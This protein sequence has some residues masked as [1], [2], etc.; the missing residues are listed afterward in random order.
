[1]TEV[2]NMRKM[3]KRLGAVLMAAV[4]LLSLVLP[5]Y[6]VDTEG[7]VV[8]DVVFEQQ[9]T[10]IGRGLEVSFTFTAID[11][12]G[13]A[14][15]AEGSWV[16]FHYVDT[17]EGYRRECTSVEALEN[18]RYRMTF[19]VND[20]SLGKMAVSEWVVADSAGNVTEMMCIDGEWPN[21]I[22]TFQRNLPVQSSI[23]L[24]FDEACTQPAGTK[25][26]TD[27][28][29][30]TSGE[31][32]IPLYAKQTGDEIDYAIC[33]NL[34]VQLKHDE[35][36]QDMYGDLTYDDAKGIWVGL[37][38]MSFIDKHGDYSLYS[39]TTTTPG[40]E[41]YAVECSNAGEFSLFF[42]EQNTDNI[43]PVLEDVYF[44]QNG[45]KIE[46]AAAVNYNDTV[47]LHLKV[48]DAKPDGNTTATSG[49]HVIFAYLRNDVGAA[50]DD[51]SMDYRGNDAYPLTYDAATGY[52]VGDV[53]VDE[54][55]GTQ[56]YLERVYM[57]D[58]YDNINTAYPTDVSFLLTDA[59]GNC[60]I[61][62]I[63]WEYI[64]RLSHVDLDDGE[65]IPVSTTGK[66][67]RFGDLGLEAPE[68]E[69][70]EF[71]YWAR[72]VEDRQLEQLTDDSVIRVSQ[73]EQINFWPVYDSYRGMV[74]VEYCDKNGEYRRECYTE[75]V[76]GTNT[77]RDI[78]DN[79]GVDL[80][81]I[82][83]FEDYGFTG[84]W[85]GEN[86]LDLAVSIPFSVLMLNAQYDAKI[87]RVYGE[88][89][90]EDLNGEVQE[91]QLRFE[92]EPTHADVLAAAEEALADVQHAESLGF[93][94]WEWLDGESADINEPA[95]S[96]YV[97][98][99]Q[100]EKALV[101]VQ[102]LISVDSNGGRNQQYE[103][104][105]VEA[106]T[107]W[108]SFLAGI[109]H[110]EL[111]EG[112]SEWV[113]GDQR[114][115]EIRGSE[116]IS[117]VPKYDSYALTYTYYYM[118]TAGDIV[119]GSK[120]LTYA[121]DGGTWLD[122]FDTLTLPA[123]AKADVLAWM[124]DAELPFES[125]SVPMATEITAYALYGDAVPVNAAY[126]YIDA[127]GEPVCREELVYVD[128]GDDMDSMLLDAAAQVMDGAVHHAE[129]THQGDEAYNMTQS[130][131]ELTE[132]CMTSLLID[133]IAVYDKILVRLTMPDG[134]VTNSLV[135]DFA[136]ITLPGTYNGRKIGWDLDIGIEQ[137]W[138]EDDT[139]LGEGYCPWLVGVASYVEEEAD[140]SPSPSTDPS[141]APSTAP[142]PTPSQTPSAGVPNYNTYPA[143]TPSA[144]PAVVLTEE[145]VEEL[146]EEIGTAADGTVIEIDMSQK[147]TVDGKTATVVPVE[148]LEAVK[149][150]DV[151]IV[152]DM[153]DY[154]WTINGQNVVGQN[155]QDINLEVKA[156]TNAVPPSIVNGLAGDRPTTQLSLTHNGD[157]GF[158]ATLKINVGDEHAGELG[159]LF[160]Y[161]SNHKLVFI[162]KGE[163]DDLGDV[164]LDFAHAS[165]YVIVIGNMDEPEDTMEA[166]VVSAGDI[167]AE[168]EEEASAAEV[169]EE[170]E[171][172]RRGGLW[173]II[174]LFVLLV[175]ALTA[176]IVIFRKKK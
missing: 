51:M 106:G 155:L 174:L 67:V 59:D 171:E 13:S 168:P 45:T 83:H 119:S 84:S 176:V 141:P 146:V 170:P 50:M 76:T 116:F 34:R 143:P 4:I 35:L 65:P 20:D 63:D 28:E 127:Q 126:A 70:R 3:M 36:R 46:N 92:G 8:T 93:A 85:E 136:D 149:G 44:S 64:V 5:V 112:A 81:A 32:N 21:F 96:E 19:P 62:Q 133:I 117:F 161:D 114:E 172:S 160:Y 22:Y 125:L 6:A 78:L 7:P 79:A 33:R 156:D 55:Y 11:S 71:L 121:P 175:I 109:T 104:F 54:L 2:W 73:G 12:Y 162:S 157:F 147:T 159:N 56:W 90:R 105:V 41:Q 25:T 29:Y 49:V 57:T 27:S 148:I 94:G 101:E 91:L 123:G 122:F 37:L 113:C 130:A 77:F 134:T 60:V 38:N 88:Y 165:D 169:T 139:E 154:S 69:G 99:A 163:I 100:Y 80:G 23:A 43:A 138:I 103:Q 110:P 61:P 18:N 111:P 164:E 124:V 108:E 26:M 17:D 42:D 82:T 150:K 128:F 167:K 15:A 14:V 173:V 120:S 129:R 132:S 31:Y 68:A 152:L 118:N 47:K 144:Q 40:E 166:P 142:S 72:E 75:E 97:F 89:V 140:P 58:L 98:V 153:G 137:A 24:Y 10:D 39:I 115:G 74:I 48:T 16:S 102:H 52:Y 151:N 66:T 131:D 107:T 135:D 86:D 9:D 145:R 95:W 87:I 1:M 53:P 158:R 30:L